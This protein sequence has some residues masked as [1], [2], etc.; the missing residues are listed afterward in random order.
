MVKYS[1]ATCVAIDEWD[2]KNRVGPYYNLKEMAK[3]LTSGGKP[4]IEHPNKTKRRL[5]K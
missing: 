5:G 1:L 4:N 2:K 3:W